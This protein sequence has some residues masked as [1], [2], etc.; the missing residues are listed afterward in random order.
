MKKT[1]ELQ[2]SKGLDAPFVMPRCLT[3]KFWEQNTFYDYEGAVNDGVC[4]ELNS[5]IDI[6][7]RLGWEGGYV[8]S[9]ET[10]STF[11]CVLHNGA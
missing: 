6:Q 7:L 5:E 1:N 3:C 4:S 10:K 9:I 2:E 8:N 11:G